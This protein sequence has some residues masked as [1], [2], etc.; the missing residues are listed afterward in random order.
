MLCRAQLR[1]Y[2]EEGNWTWKVLGFIAGL[3]MMANG[4]L[5]FL[6]ELTSLSPLMA[7]LDIYMFCFG[8]ICVLLEYKEQAL[9]QKYI[10]IIRREALFLYKPYGR[11]AFYMLC[12]SILLAKGGIL[13]PLI[14][15]FV[16]CIGLLLFSSS[17]QAQR[18]LDVLREQQFNDELMSAKFQE[19]DKNNDGYLNA[20]E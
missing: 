6:V 2:A 11:G 1:K 14:G 3:L 20:A 8:L 7:V 17:R 18:S 9:T 12:G 15:L 4:V 16:C 5:S 10:N 19:F 13:S